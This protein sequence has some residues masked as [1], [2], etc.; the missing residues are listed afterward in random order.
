[1]VEG[2]SDREDLLN[3]DEFVLYDIDHERL[4]IVGGLASRILK[5]R[6]FHGKLIFSENLEEAVT[7]ASAVLIQLRVGGQITRLKDE[8]LPNP[9]GLIGQETTGPGGFFKALRTVPVLIDIADTVRRLAGPDCWIIDFTNPVGIETRALLDAGHKAI[10]L[11]NVGIGF[12]RHIAKIYGVDPDLVRLDHAGLNHLT[13]IR[14]VLVD[15]Q[16]KLDELLATTDPDVQ[17][18]F[19]VAQ[20]CCQTLHAIPSYYLHYFY[21]TD[22]ELARQLGG[23]HRAQ[24]VIEIEHELLEMYKDPA[25]DHKPALLEERGGAYYSTAA[26]ALTVSLLT[27]DGAHHYI[28][29]RNNGTLPGLPDEAVVEVPALVDMDGPHPVKIMPLAKEML[30]LVQNITAYEELTIEAALSG[31]P[32]IAKRALIANPLVRQWDKVDS[33]FD[34][35]VQANA[36]LLPRFAGCCCDD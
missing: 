27:G 19:P 4:Q 7:G 2:F 25:L 15:G 23:E 18:L 29:T 34:S 35:M 12:Q 5:K 13:W 31:D 1:L 16:E 11:C 20:A 36:P 17:D 14:S 21:E 24:R 10:G 28:N 33:C 8:T 6:G 22:H 9:F 30:G 26:A 32:V 3:L